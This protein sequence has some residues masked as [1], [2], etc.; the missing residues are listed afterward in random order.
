MI[1]D[2][3]NGLSGRRRGGGVRIDGVPAMP[4]LRICIGV[5]VVRGPGEAFT[6]G[7]LAFEGRSRIGRGADAGGL[8][9][10]G[11]LTVGVLS[12]PGLFADRVCICFRERGGFVT[13]AVLVTRVG[14]VVRFGVVACG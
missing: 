13:L 3:T 12:L 7:E 2:R 4:G 8:A 5:A 10:C 6:G 1:G 9:F 11:L 14:V